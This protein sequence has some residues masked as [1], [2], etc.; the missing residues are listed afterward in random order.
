MLTLDLHVYA[1]NQ[2]LK[3][4]VVQAAEYAYRYVGAMNMGCARLLLH[5][6]NILSML[7][8][9]VVSVQIYVLACILVVGGRPSV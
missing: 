4:C 7:P 6:E 8:V 2:Y 1:S 3:S 5:W 9:L